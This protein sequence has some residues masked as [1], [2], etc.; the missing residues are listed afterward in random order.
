MKNLF[1]TAF[2]A[3]SVMAAAVA[4]AQAPASSPEAAEI[5]SKGVW[6]SATTYAKDDIVTA[7]GSAWISLKPGNI[8]QLPGQTAPSTATWWRLFARGFNPTGAWSNSAIYH[9]DDIVTRLGQTYR[10]KITH[11]NKQPPSAANWELL[12][13]KGADGAAGPQ[14][15][16]GAQGLQ[17]LQGEPGAKGDKGDKGNKGD[18]GDTG[19]TG[20]AG[21]PGTK[22]ILQS[23]NRNYPQFDEQF[24][25][26]VCS[27]T[28]VPTGGKVTIT[29]QLPLYAYDTDQIYY[30]LWALVDGVYTNVVFAKIGYGAL[31]YLG[32][33]AASAYTRDT[34][35]FAWLAQPEA[36]KSVTY[37]IAVIATTPGAYPAHS[38][39]P[40]CIIQAAEH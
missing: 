28:I 23:E 37:S 8:N 34:R 1:V 3:A 13:T 11:T 35:S 24:Y 17:G 36:N 20:P 6:N 27:V 31:G 14:G 32:G 26:N 39:G 33:T 21:A 25:S 29:G 10:A 15:L 18:T 7:R 2:F 40:P 9:P 4:H 5:A 19:P 38:S 16:Q 30:T 22:Q 12:V